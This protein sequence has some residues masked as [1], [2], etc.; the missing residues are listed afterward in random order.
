MYF[1]SGD[2]ISAFRGCCPFDFLHALEIDQGLI[3]HTPR[4]SG[5]L[6][7]NFKRENL[8]FGLKVSVLES[9]TSWQVE[10]S[11]RNFFS[12]CAI[13]ARRILTT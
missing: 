2:N 12:L 11:S 9:V 5:V 7:N 4:G 6:P 13:A 1:F 10:V 8:K 3:A